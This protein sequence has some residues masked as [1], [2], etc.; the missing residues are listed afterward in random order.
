MLN[1]DPETWMTDALCAETDP[2]LFF[3]T[4]KYEADTARRICAACPVT[5]ACREYALADDSLRGIWGG[6]DRRDRARLRARSAAA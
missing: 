4:D 6:T 1:L 5:A 2:D 3:P